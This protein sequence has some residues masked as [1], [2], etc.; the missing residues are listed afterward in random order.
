MDG[1]IAIALPAWTL[2]IIIGFLAAITFLEGWRI[3]LLLQERRERRR[4]RT[5]LTFL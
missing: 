5:R 4:Y 1:I 2:W 3:L